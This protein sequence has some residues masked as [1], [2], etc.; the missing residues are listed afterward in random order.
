MSLDV[1]SLHVEL[2]ELT[3]RLPPPS[4]TQE[5]IP[6]AASPPKNPAARS[7][8]PQH[9]GVASATKAPSL[10]LPAGASRA[11]PAPQQLPASLSKMYQERLAG[12]RSAAAAVVPGGQAAGEQKK[13]E[14]CLRATIAS[15]LF[16]ILGLPLILVL[17]PFIIIKACCCPD[18]PK[19]G[20]EGEQQQRPGPHNV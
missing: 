15:L 1:A 14:G 6:Y 11:A 18:P 13:E 17:L 9:A 2:S 19:E 10:Q 4:R 12:S 7:P 16:A 3:K 8:A 5:P 20:Q